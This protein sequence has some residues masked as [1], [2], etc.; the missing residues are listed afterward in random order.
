MT[1]LLRY[2]R[3][4]NVAASDPG[5]VAVLINTRALTVYFYARSS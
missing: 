2:T 1:V 4:M 3:D 5:P